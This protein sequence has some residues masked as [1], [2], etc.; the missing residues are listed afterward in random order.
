MAPSVPSRSLPA[1]IFAIVKA[2]GQFVNQ[3]ASILLVAIAL[4]ACGEPQR[5]VQELQQDPEKVMLEFYS[6]PGPEDTLM[7]PLIVAGPSI[8]SLVIAAVENPDMP[9]RRYAIGF[10]GNE[11]VAEALPLLT[12]ILEDE[13]ELP[14]FRGD[15]LE[16][17]YKIDRVRA[18][19]FAPEFQDRE[20]ALGYY[21]SAVL[22]DAPSL[23]E[24]RSLAKARIRRHD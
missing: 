2:T 9:R 24:R 22:E 16:A 17:I 14:Y 15:A 4:V 18:K 21:A 19:D 8:Y 6:N 20:D 13:S 12:S 3:A 1:K 23:S 10:L 5:A 11:E 7:D